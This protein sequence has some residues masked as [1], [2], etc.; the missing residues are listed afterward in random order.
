V[1]L[2]PMPGTALKSEFPILQRQIGGRPLTYLDNAATTQKPRAVIDALVRF[3][4]CH[5]ANVHRGVHTLSEEAT[6]LY[7]D[8]R[9]TVAAFL[10]APAPRTV[11]FTRGTTEALNLVALG[12]AR[13]RLR[14]GDEILVSEMEHHSNLVPWQVAA[15]ERGARV[16]LVRV[17]PD[18]LLDREDY[19]AKLG[20][21]TR[22]VALTHTS[23]VL[24]TVNPLPELIAAARAVGAA[25]AVDAAQ[26][27]AKKP[28]DVA[29]LGCDFLAFSGHKVFGPTG[30]GALYVAEAR[31]AELE[32]VYSGGGMI[33]RVDADGATWADAPWKFEA[34]TPPIEQA[35]GLAAALD[36]LTAQERPALLA[37][38]RAL[39]A[40]ALQALADCPGV[41][42]YGPRDP[43]LRAGVLSFNLA[44]L[45]PHDVA[46]VLDEQGVAV[47]GGHHCCQ[48]LMRRF[49]VPAM[50]RASLAPYNDA[51]DIDRLVAGLHRVRRVLGHG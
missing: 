16:R 11:V 29:A 8:A 32:P 6:G 49:E 47:R 48:P 33:R 4:E 28:L 44:G 5:N 23:N 1:T 3:Y 21:R 12:W 36:W 50:V 26:A 19:A 13:P 42:T 30:I 2:H 22:L 34:G 9:G 37:H 25:F 17:T 24:G 41:T 35:V 18:G 45:H 10:G 27:A 7:E 14:A 20:P 15:Q 31:L 39:T 51:E 40:H 38:E 46:E 43:L